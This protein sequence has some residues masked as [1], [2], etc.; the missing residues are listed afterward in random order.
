MT[1]LV[2]G[3]KD[4]LK[5]IHELLVDGW[6][7]PYWV[8]GIIDLLLLMNWDFQRCPLFSSGINKVGQRELGNE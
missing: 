8:T 6:I 1:S 7:H 2:G 3:F 5:P 4:H